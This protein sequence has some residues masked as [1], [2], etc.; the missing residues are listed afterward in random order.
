MATFS[1]F[2][3]T[4]SLVTDNGPCFTSSEFAKFVDQWHFQHISLSPRYPQSNGKAQNAVCTVKRPFTKRRAAGVS[5]FQALLVWRI[6]PC[7]GMD[8]SPARLMGR[9]C[10]TLLPTSGTLQ[11]PEFSVDND[12]AKLCARKERQRR[13]FSRDKRILCPV[14][15]GE[16]IRVRSPTETW[17]PA[18]C[19]P[20]RSCST[21]VR[22]SSC[23]S[24]ASSK[25]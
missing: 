17:K 14:K 22:G 10:N 16:I 19:L 11:M 12:A 4:D 8:T 21:I 20:P 25:S 9:R 5:E 6:T 2:G 24:S 23:W 3:V 13:Y 7:E 1:R 15:A 18:E